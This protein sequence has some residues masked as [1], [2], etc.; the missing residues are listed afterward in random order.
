MRPI[1]RNLGRNDPLYFC[2]KRA[3]NTTNNDNLSNFGCNVLD[4]RY[5]EGFVV[6]VDLEFE[7]D[8]HLAM[9]LLK[10]S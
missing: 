6:D 4:I 2:W 5:R 10:W 7:S 3:I 1:F 9:F 8:A